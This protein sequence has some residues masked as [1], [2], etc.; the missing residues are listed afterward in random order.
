VDSGGR[1]THQFNHIR[2]AA[3]MRPD[4]TAHWRHLAYTIEP[5][6]CGGDAVLCQITLTTCSLLR[7]HIR[8]AS[9]SVLE[10]PV[11]NGGAVC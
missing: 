1:T 9:L 11:R 4:G 7:Q 2:Q 10:M 6:V 5:S 8:P 3:P